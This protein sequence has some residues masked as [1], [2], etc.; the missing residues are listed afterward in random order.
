MQTV[1][2]LHE[3][4]SKKIN[5]IC[6]I[7]EKINYK[8]EE[9]IALNNFYLSFVTEY[10]IANEQDTKLF[11]VFHNFVISESI[12]SKIDDLATAIF[13]KSK[14]TEAYLIHEFNQIG[15]IELKVK[16]N[17]LSCNN[18]GNNN[19]T[20]MQEIGEYYCVDC[21]CV[22][23]L[24]GEHYEHTENARNISYKPVKHC[25]DWIK[26]IFGIEKKIIPNELITKI[27]GCMSRDGVTTPSY[28]LFR[29]YLK[30]LKQT[31]FNNHIVKLR[32]QITGI[33][34]PVPSTEQYNNICTKFMIQDYYYNQIRDTLSISRI[35][36]PSLISKA[37]EEEYKNSPEILNLILE[38]IHV[39]EYS[40][41]QK[42]DKIYK[43]ICEISN[44]EL[45]YT[46][47]RE[48]R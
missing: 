34:P 39:Q 19:F 46:K 3:Q 5:I 9:C 41:I 47:P 26:Q 13:K 20:I 2:G 37:I 44:G 48:Y 4:I 1:S 21:G 11:D 28:Q 18:C 42:H 24:V 15:K 30:E 23:K 22:N 38:G 16:Q 12:I 32:R 35:Y 31:K 14:S 45:V 33:G 6:K 36:Y 40:T 27:M 29:E 43:K 10:I 25:E 7:A 8:N 17:T